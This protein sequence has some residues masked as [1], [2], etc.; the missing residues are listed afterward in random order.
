MENK[1][2]RHDATY[3][4][5][6][7]TCYKDSLEAKYPELSNHPDVSYKRI[8]PEYSDGCVWAR[9]TNLLGLNSDHDFLYQI[10]SHMLFDPNWDRFLVEDWKKARKKEGHDKVIISGS[11]K[12][13]VMNPDLGPCQ[14][15]YESPIT[16]DVKYFNI[17]PVNHC[18]KAHGDHIPAKPEPFKGFHILAGNFFTHRDWAKN[19][20]LVPESFY[21]TEEPLMT[22]MS[23]EKGYAVY[24]HSQISCYHLD[25]TKDYITKQWVNPVVNTN[26]INKSME[27]SIKIW[28][29]YLDD[30]EEE[31]LINFY[32]DFGVD[33]I[34]HVI[35]DRAR[36][37][38]I[39][40]AKERMTESDIEYYRNNNVPLEDGTMI[41]NKII[42]DTSKVPS[43]IGKPRKKVKKPV[44]AKV[45]GLE[46][47][48]INIEKEILE[49]TSN[50]TA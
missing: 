8:D 21:D 20:G 3:A 24:H 42:E 36:T 22:F 37:V 46:V 32:K 13:F 34:N 5:L 16:S 49:E 19:V 23:Y 30:V 9:S 14:V 43:V 15:N 17:D 28:K 29:K 1:S 45:I 18:P 41:Q 33:M 47:D 25:D 44:V 10:D 12:V 26:K 7:Q 2:K 40:V 48:A 38:T 27:R 11:C 39:K 50:A 4:I 31:V 35:D 6:E